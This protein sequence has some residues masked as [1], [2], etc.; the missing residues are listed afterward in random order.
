MLNEIERKRLV[1]R[2]PAQLQ[3]GTVRAPVFDDQGWLIVE[4]DNESG[5]VHSCPWPIGAVP[6]ADDGVTVMESD[7][8]NYWVVG[9]W[10]TA[11]SR[12]SVARGP[13]TAASGNIAAG[14]TATQTVTHGL[15]LTASQAAN[16]VI[17]GNLS[18]TDADRF[19]WSVVSKTANSFVIRFRNNH[20]ATAAATLTAAIL[21]WG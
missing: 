19:S 5:G 2:A 17:T 1:Q 15:G 18:G 16:Q 4:L 6:Q 10:P 20:N 8:G 12:R 21:T 7:E 11:A 3:E 14:A 13:F 9:W